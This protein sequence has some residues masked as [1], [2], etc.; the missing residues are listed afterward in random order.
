[1]PRARSE[2]M[3]AS[4][5]AFFGRAVTKAALPPSMTTEAATL[6]SAP[7]KVTSM[8]PGMAW[9]NRRNP[10]GASRPMISPKVITLFI[11]RALQVCHGGLARRARKRFRMPRPHGG[12]SPPWHSESVSVPQPS[13][14]ASFAVSR[15]LAR[16]GGDGVPVAGGDGLLLRDPRAA[17][18]EHQRA[19]HVIDH[20][21]RVHAAERHEADAE[22]RVRGGH[23]LQV[24]QAA[25]RLGREELQDAAAQLERLFDLR[26]RRHAGREG[27]A[28]LLRGLEH[29]RVRAR[30]HG[31]RRA[32]RM[33]VGHLRGRQDGTHAGQH[34][35]HLSHHRPK[36]VHRRRRAQ[37]QLHRLHAAR[38]Q[39]PRQRHGVLGALHR[40][41]GDHAALL[42]LL[43]DAVVEHCLSSV[44]K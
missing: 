30:C 39:R 7:A 5:M 1:M 15:R 36:R 4:A 19:P 24:G 40:Q 38:Q 44:R 29:G 3:Q 34:L 8:L 20:V 16:G 22:V 18:A 26:G 12:A 2:A 35:G 27:K 23:A 42:D 31:E 33:H 14:R 6:A 9:A 13:V 21:R 17:D 37:R 28:H 25:D 41:H 10:G 43:R 11:S 32:R